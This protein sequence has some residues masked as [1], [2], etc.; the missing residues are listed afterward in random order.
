[1]KIIR[2]NKEIEIITLLE[3]KEKAT[4]FKHFKG[5]NYSMVS[6]GKDADNLN[7]V[8]I[9]K[10]L[11]GEGQIWVREYNEF[12]SKVDKEKHPEIKQKYRFEI[13]C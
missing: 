4:V 1:M 8:V 5:N 12:F 6:V 9:Y 11:Y 3:S 13:K 2:D 7:E 10:A